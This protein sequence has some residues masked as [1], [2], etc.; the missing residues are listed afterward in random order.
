MAI[1]SPFEEAAAHTLGIEGGFSDHP[2]DRG[3]ATQWGITEAVARGDGYT[4][5][6]ADLPK[7]RALSIY[8]RLY[9][10]RIGLDWIAAV[11]RDIAAELFDTGVNMGVSVAVIFLQRVLNALNRQGRDYPDLKVDGN[12][13]PATATA[14][15]ALIARRGIV[16]R[17][18]VLT[19]LNAL[20]GARYVEL[21]EGRAANE[22]FMLGWAQRVAFTFPLSIRKAA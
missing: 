1:L 11:D 5:A 21:A 3:G 19:Y 22:N 17:N 8:R 15:R 14:L 2:S 4:G 7:S 20:Q 10:D 9:W 18:A 13:G 12:A 6:M 16:G